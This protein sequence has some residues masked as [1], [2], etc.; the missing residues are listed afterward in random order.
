MIFNAPHQD[1]FSLYLS[2]G[3]FLPQTE[4]GRQKGHDSCD[5]IEHAIFRPQRF[6]SPRHVS[7]HAREPFSQPFPCL[8]EVQRKLSAT[9]RF[10]MRRW[11]SLVVMFGPITIETGWACMYSE[12]ETNLS[13]PA[14]G[15]RKTNCMSKKTKE[16]FCRRCNSNTIWSE[17]RIVLLLEEVMPSASVVSFQR[18]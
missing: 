2:D 6:R 18:I 10:D 11:D 13:I 9:G 17:S 1:T 7:S 14:D 3:T 16:Q 12:A 4:L 8:A 5:R 15:R